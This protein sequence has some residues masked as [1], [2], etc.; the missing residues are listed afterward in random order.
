MH[1]NA[2]W[3]GGF[4]RNI[5]AVDAFLF[6][7][8]RFVLSLVRIVARGGPDREKTSAVRAFPCIS[9]SFSA[10]GMFDCGRA[11]VRQGGL[12]V[13]RECAKQ[14]GGPWIPL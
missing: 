10:E 2:L 11:I 12:K 5:R 1:G 13:S 7:E 14:M 4:Y 9:G 6:S 3:A 8:R